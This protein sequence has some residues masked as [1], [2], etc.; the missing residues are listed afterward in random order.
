VLFKKFEALKHR[1]LGD[2][3]KA[4]SSELA[5]QLLDSGSLGIIYP[6]VRNVGGTN[7]V[8]FRPALVGD[9]RKT[10]KFEF[11]WSGSGQ[12]KITKSSVK[13]R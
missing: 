11:V 7:L 5:S 4:S 10:D 9:V 6:S 2:D 3:R 12:P 13:P 8:C 1:F